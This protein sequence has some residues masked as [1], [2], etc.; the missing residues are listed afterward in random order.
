MRLAL[1]C[2]TPHERK[3]MVC[4]AVGYFSAIEVKVPSTRGPVQY[5]KCEFY[6]DGFG[7]REQPGLINAHRLPGGDAE[8]RVRPN[9]VSVF[10]W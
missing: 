6:K 7:T 10:T 5:L 8:T 2:W 1:N 4:Q 3:E 9:T